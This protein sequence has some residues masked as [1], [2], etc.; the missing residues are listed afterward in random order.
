MSELQRIAEEWNAEWQKAFITSVS[1]DGEYFIK[2][3]FKTMADMHDAYDALV[4][5]ADA[6]TP[7]RS[8]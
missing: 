8:E 2:A 4:K 3:K 6:S 1:A 5:L 7:A